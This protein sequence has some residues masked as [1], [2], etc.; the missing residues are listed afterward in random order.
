MRNR[1]NAIER[2]PA[3]RG[4]G[5]RLRFIEDA[6]EVSGRVFPATADEAD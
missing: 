5:W 4:G 3:D 1:S 6:R 2:Y